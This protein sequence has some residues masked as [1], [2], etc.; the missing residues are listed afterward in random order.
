MAVG[1]PA[2][3]LGVDLLIAEAKHR[4]RRRRF[5]ALGLIVVVAAA[6][7]GVTR[8]TRSAVPTSI[9]RFEAAVHDR[10]QVSDVTSSGGV[11]VASV[12]TGFWMTT[13]D[14]ATWRRAPKISNGT[15]EF[16]NR[17]DGWFVTTGPGLARTTDGGRTWQRLA[18]PGV[19]P[20]VGGVSVSLS[21]VSPAV[22][23]VD[24]RPYVKETDELFA[25]ADGGTTWQ[26]RTLPPGAYLLGFVT[27]RLGFIDVGGTQY[28][29]A[30]GGRTW[31]PRQRLCPATFVIAR[32]FVRDC[33]SRGSALFSSLPPAYLGAS[34]LSAR[35][36]V[37]GGPAG[38]YVTTS[39]GRTW[40]FVR[41]LDVPRHWHFAA[42]TFTSTRTGWAVFRRRTHGQV[43]V[44]MR[45]TDRG[46][47]WTPAGPLKP[48]T[49]KHG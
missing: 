6:A 22:G 49:H 1:I 26:R 42:G 8:E 39:A 31:S 40:R 44:L 11:V 47:H 16:V 32:T 34:A 37:V 35:S 17:R 7:I 29:T 10:V 48:T 41:A 25:T 45:T 28:S 33:A 24:V 21:F 9:A 43:G 36:W 27:A 4:A 2:V 18:A 30:D 5:I 12:P 13:D 46:R 15:P 23:F 20:D 38:N 14:G 19:T 3:P